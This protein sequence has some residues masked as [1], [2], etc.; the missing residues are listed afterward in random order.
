[1]SKG[2]GSLAASSLFS[3]SDPDG[4]AITQYDLWNTGVGGATFVVNGVS[5]G[6]NQ[7]IYLTP[8]Q[9][10]QTT[11]QPGSAPDT[12]WVRAFDGVKWSPWSH[13]FTVSPP[14]DNPPVVTVSNLT[15]S[16]GQSL[17]ASS[18][19]SASDPD[20][21]TIT[22]YDFWD[23]GKGGGNFAVNG[24]VQP[25]N[26]D[27]YV[28]AAQLAHTTY[29]V[30]SGTD[31]VWV[32]AFDGTQWSAWSSSF[33]ITSAVASSSASSLARDRSRVDN[34]GLLANYVSAFV[35]SRDSH[36]SVS[37]LDQVFERHQSGLLTL[38]SPA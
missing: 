10:S 8:G 32:R 19:F 30:G 26:Q 18:L 2:Q 29:Q 4:D 9:L 27:N 15:A 31:T 21:D 14:A 37:L 12:L 22:Q 5:Q 20:G 13:S 28:P 24:V 38:A 16:K 7:D 3:A 35:T 11:Y 17:A 34:T 33:T 25:T 6:I 23:T 36:G 1:M